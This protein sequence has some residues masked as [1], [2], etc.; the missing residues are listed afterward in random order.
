[1]SESRKKRRPR[2]RLAPRLEE[3]DG[4]LRSSL[5]L[6]SS[7]LTGSDHIQKPR[8]E[9]Q[10][11]PIR[12]PKP[13]GSPPT[14]TEEPW[15]RLL[16]IFSSNSTR[17]DYEIITIHSQNP[18]PYKA[19]SYAWGDPGC[20]RDI[21]IVRGKEQGWL[22]VPVSLC[23]ALD[24]LR[25]QEE[26]ILVWA[27][28]VCINQQD[29]LEK[30]Q[31]LPLICD[32]YSEAKQVVVWLGVEEDDSEQA[33]ELLQ[34]LSNVKKSLNEPLNLRSVVSLFDRDYWSRL[35]VVQE[36]LHA[37]NVVVL[38]GSSRLSWDAYTQCSTIFQSKDSADRLESLL[39]ERHSSTRYITSQHRLSPSQVLIHHGPASILHLQQAR[40]V[41]G[42]DSPLYTLFLMRLS[43]NKLATDPKD[44]VYGVL[45][46]LPA[47]IRREIR[48]DYRLPIKDIYIDIVEMIMMRS[49]SLDVLCESIH[50]PPQISSASLPSWVPD[51]SYDPTTQSLAS[52]SLSFSAS[53]ALPAEHRYVEDGWD[54]PRRNKLVFA[55]VRIGSI[56]NH[57]MTVNTHSRAVDYCMAFLQWRA[58]LLQYF[59]LTSG[60]ES[61][62]A[63]R[64]QRVSLCEHQRR[65]CLTLSLGQPIRT[66]TDSKRSDLSDLEKSWL[67]KCYCVFSNLIKARLPRLPIDE[68]LMAFSDIGDDMEPEVNRQFLQDNFAEYMMGRCFCITDSGDLG[69]GSGAMARGDIVV[70]PYGCS[71]PILLRPEGFSAPDCDGQRTQ[72]YRFVG[73]AYIHGYMD[74]EAIVN[75]MKEEFILH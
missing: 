3:T 42:I 16:K 56:S 15:I 19:I 26:D 11:V 52:F 48:V 65:F 57:G 60:S 12:D 28:S 30:N 44:R 37:R 67:E 32:I 45:G 17:I 2:P 25:D 4:D 34:D 43:R 69:L 29:D 7:N 22:K 51:W 74:G 35:W 36:I 46:L 1:M 54:P 20:T 27:D 71:T 72:E 59:E 40:K 70:V 50:F 9:Y 62:N 53:E 49:R 63:E 24:A 39:N 68:D 64:R 55:G 61:N 75:G 13:P 14:S 21:S 5:S 6:P 18:P 10:Y 66:N 47:R 23:A 73:D 33:Q 8:R 31:Q 58:L 38:C 41:Y